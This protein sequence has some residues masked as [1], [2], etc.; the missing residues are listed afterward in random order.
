ML[1]GQHVQFY[2]VV[3]RVKATA[4]RLLTSDPVGVSLQPVDDCYLP[5]CE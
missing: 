5:G 3:T 1:V 2:Q 4:G